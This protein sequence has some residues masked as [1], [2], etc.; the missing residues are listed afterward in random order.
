MKP[1]HPKGC[2]RLQ[3]KYENQE[4]NLLYLVVDE[5]ITPLLG[6]VACLDLEVLQFINLHL[7]D[8]PAPSPAMS[9]TPTCGDQTIFQKDPI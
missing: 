8:T 7:T 6:C 1:N 2:V 5:N 9:D 3:T 4:M